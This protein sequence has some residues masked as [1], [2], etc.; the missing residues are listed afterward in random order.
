M[1]KEKISGVYKITLK[2]DGRVYIGSSVD[3]EDRWRIHKQRNNQI[4]CK[5]IK[6]Y[7]IDAFDW[8][9]LEEVPPE[10]LLER[11]QYF[12]DCYQPFVDNGKGFNLSKEAY[13]V[14][15]IKRSQE[16]KDKMKKSSLTRK[17]DDKHFIG[18]R[19][20]VKLSE[21]HKQKLSDA[22]KGKTW[23]EDNE[24]IKKHKE[25][26]KGKKQTD[27]WIEKMKEVHNGSKRTDE[28]KKK[29]SDWQQT[30]YEIYDPNG[31]KYVMKTSELKDF[32][33]QHEFSYN[34]FQPCSNNG[35]KYRG[36][37]IKK[38]P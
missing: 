4:I 11:E 28:A 16:T 29:M 15:G 20:G 18:C 3:I 14:Y 35:K 32:C 24:R 36:W 26:R 6:K 21:E 10:N 1:S 38:C 7:G 17:D 34:A 19:A 37:T 12:L 5:A 33:I 22:M 8:Q 9:I 23:K 2:Q 31:I 27:T 30:I 25:A 13:S